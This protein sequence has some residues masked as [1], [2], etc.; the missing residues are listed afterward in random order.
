MDEQLSREPPTLGSRAVSTRASSETKPDFLVLTDAEFVPGAHQ[1]Q[2]QQLWLFRYPPD[3]LGIGH[4][5]IFQPGVDPRGTI[6]IE[7]RGESEPIGESFQLARGHW[8]NLQI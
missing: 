8:L 4:L 1:R 6:G 2:A 3:H 5:Y 7:Q